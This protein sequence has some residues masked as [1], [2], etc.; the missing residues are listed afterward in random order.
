M[1][2]HWQVNLN[3]NFDEIELE[4]NLELEQLHN[5]N[6]IEKNKDIHFKNYEKQK[7]TNN[8]KIMKKIASHPAEFFK[9]HDKSCT[10]Y[11]T[12]DAIS[13][14]YLRI[15]IPNNIE[16]KKILQKYANIELEYNVSGIKIS[17]VPLKIFYYLCEKF[18]RDIEIVNPRKLS[19]KNKP[20]IY[21]KEHSQINQRFFFD[22]SN[23]CYLDIPIIFEDFNYSHI[24][25]LISMHSDEIKYILSG[26]N[27]NEQCYI[28][29]NKVIY[30][31]SDLRKIIAT[32][33]TRKLNTNLRY[34][35]LEPSENL[36]IKNFGYTKFLFLF[37]EK[38]KDTHIDFP[39]IT[40]FT[41]TTYNKKM[42]KIV[43]NYDTTNFL[44]EDYENCRMYGVSL[45]H[46]MSMKKWMDFKK[47]ENGEDYYDIDKIKNKINEYKLKFKILYINNLN[48]KLSPYVGNIKMS[49]LSVDQHILYNAN[50]KTYR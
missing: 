6:L 16:P 9:F 24:I 10:I 8:L 2:Y 15:E 49:I 40:S 26:S 7:E 33:F 23:V 17:K 20:N 4:N 44:L 38:N 5:L 43:I 48:I 31:E 13:G 19:K 34:I 36:N 22:N 25:P 21:K 11:R 29:Y 14:A 42:N 50:G 1:R 32:T 27:I 3:K 30:Y 39:E 28:I 18:G 37:M 35:S 12:S 45:D 47:E 46:N 41:V